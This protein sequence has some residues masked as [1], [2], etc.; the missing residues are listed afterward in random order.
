MAK[1]LF[2]SLL[3]KAPWLVRWVFYI[4]WGGAIVMSS[5]FIFGWD[6]KTFTDAYITAIA[7]EV[8]DRKVGPMKAARDTE[9][10]SMK[11]DIAEMSDTIRN[12]SATLNRMEGK[13]DVWMASH[14]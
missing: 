8:F 1:G 6:S 13:L 14:K 2:E 9:L 4:F 5:S 7:S 11:N 10:T 12:N 3:E